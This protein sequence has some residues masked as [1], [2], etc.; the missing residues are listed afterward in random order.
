VSFY[1]ND[2]RV[3]PDFDGDAAYVLPDTDG[4]IRIKKSQGWWIV[5]RPGCYL[6]D[7]GDWD[8]QGPRIFDSADDAIHAVIGDPK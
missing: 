8:I 2:S 3:A 6:T 4:P 5:R 7:S 1:D